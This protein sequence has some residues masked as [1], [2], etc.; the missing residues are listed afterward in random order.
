MKNKGFT[1]IE[2]LVVISIIGLL[3]SV[4]IASVT[5]AR[6]KAKIQKMN[7]DVQT[8][9][10]ILAYAQGESG[11]TLQQIS[12][13]GNVT[14]PGWSEGVTECMAPNDLRNVPED[15][16]CYKE[17]MAVLERIRIHAGDMGENLKY[18][19]R[20]AWGSPYL[21]D[22]NQGA[23]EFGPTKCST[24]DTL[25]SAGPD[26]IRATADDVG[27]TYLMPLSATCN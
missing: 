27:F 17:W 26:G 13:G 3:S 21:V 8:F 6:N 23:A 1:L 14:K 7:S 24:R 9:T 5:Q 25:R 15:N 18:M 20:D 4:V 11:K 22:Q 19:N 10:R 16:N 12:T 2:L